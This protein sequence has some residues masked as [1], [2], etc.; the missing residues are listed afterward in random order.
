MAT[1]IK[2][3]NR[4]KFRSKNTFLLFLQSRYDEYQERF[5]AEMPENEALKWKLLRIQRTIE[6]LNEMTDNFRYGACVT[7]GH[8]IEDARME[9]MPEAIWCKSCAEEYEEQKKKS[10]K[11]PWRFSII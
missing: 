1:L 2:K 9:L 7:C 11:N 8:E 10:P 5:H 4:R 6:H 3:F